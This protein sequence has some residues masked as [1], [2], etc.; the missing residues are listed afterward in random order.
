MT[1]PDGVKSPLI[2]ACPGKITPGVSESLVSVNID[3]GPTSLELAGL[4]KSPRLQ[5]VSITKLFDEISP[6]FADRPG[7]YTRII[8][9]GHRR[10]DGAEMA[11]LEL[12][13]RSDEA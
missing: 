10:G 7:G 8:K 9:L 5:G 6:R 4:K 1:V 13:E 3:L 11:L 2:I 12:V